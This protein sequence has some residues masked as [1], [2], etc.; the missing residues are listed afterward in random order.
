MLRRPTTNLGDMTQFRVRGH[1]WGGRQPLQKWF[2]AL[3]AGNTPTSFRP[4]DHS[5][6][7]DP[8]P[9]YTQ[10]YVLRAR[11]LRRLECRQ[12]VCVV[13]V[14]CVCAH[15]CVCVC[16]RARV[17]VVCARFVLCVSVA[18]TP[19]P[20][21]SVVRD[22]CDACP[23]HPHAPREPPY[24]RTPVIPVHLNAR[25]CTPSAR[26]CACGARARSG[27]DKK[28]RASPFILSS[29]TAPGFLHGLGPLRSLST[30]TRLCIV[31]VWVAYGVRV[32]GT[33]AHP[34]NLRGSKHL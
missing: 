18:P 21:I 28:G 9:N 2:S 29:H 14:L 33:H 27:A 24:F 23:R 15:V 16:V 11:G 26:T 32:R 19:T 17:C 30:S 25:S 12:G 6:I 4:Q 3:R 20:Q 13:R 31:C 8:G 7:A 22:P 5:Q 34:A 1:K 10:N